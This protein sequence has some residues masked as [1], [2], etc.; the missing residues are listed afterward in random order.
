M[1]KDSCSDP[2]N[3]NLP[4]CAGF[5][6]VTSSTSTSLAT[7]KNNN[8]SSFTLNPFHIVAG[9]AMC[10]NAS[11]TLRGA[12]YHIDN[13]NL[14]SFLG[15]LRPAVLGIGWFFAIRVFLSGFNV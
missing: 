11:V 13:S 12:T 4:R 5:G 10:P 3:A 9:A 1:A 15:M 2:V 8:L 6:K 7:D 14:C